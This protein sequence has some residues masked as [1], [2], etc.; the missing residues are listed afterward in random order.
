MPSSTFFQRT[1]ESAACSGN[2]SRSQFASLSWSGRAT[3]YVGERCNMVTFA[4][5]SASAGTSV[6]AVA[7]LPITTTRLPAQSMSSVQRCGCTT[8][9]LKRSIP[10][11][12]GVYPAS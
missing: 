12:T 1:I 5:L 3:M 4:A 2:F 6:T 8:R 9:P 11:N 7:P 10:G